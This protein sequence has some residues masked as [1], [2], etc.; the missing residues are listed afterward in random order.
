MFRRLGGKK[1]KGIKQEKKES[2][3]GTKLPGFIVGLCTY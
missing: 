3:F 2:G 1:G